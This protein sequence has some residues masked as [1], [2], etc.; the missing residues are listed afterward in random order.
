MT[1]WSLI[2]QKNHENNDKDGHHHETEDQEEPLHSFE[3]ILFLGGFLYPTVSE[4]TG[5]FGCSFGKIDH[6]KH[7]H[8]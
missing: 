3:F 7:N 2:E 4:A 8:K 1:N 5:S 6:E